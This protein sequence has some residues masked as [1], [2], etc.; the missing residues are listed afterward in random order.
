MDKLLSISGRF[1]YHYLASIMPTI[2]LNRAQL[3]PLCQ[4]IQVVTRTTYH[5]GSV[6]QV[7]RKQLRKYFSCKRNSKK[8]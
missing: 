8:N 2:Q 5:S 6:R 1:E 3:K 4:F 7:L